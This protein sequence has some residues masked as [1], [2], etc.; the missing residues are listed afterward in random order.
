MPLRPWGLKPIFALTPQAKGRVERLFKTLQDRLIA[1]MALNSITTIEAANRFLD[2]VFIKDFNKRFAVSAEEPI[3]AWRETSPHID[4]ER[5]IGFRYGATVGNDN[6]V[7]LGG[8][9]IDILP[10]PKRRSYA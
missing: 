6:T 8:V 2:T 5:V 1:E 9:I 10:G 4:L 3:K 7:R